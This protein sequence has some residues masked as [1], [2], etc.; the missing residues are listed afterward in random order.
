MLVYDIGLLA[1]LI[2]GLVF[3][4]LFM[5]KYG[6]VFDV[7][8]LPCLTCISFAPIAWRSAPD[9]LLPNQMQPAPPYTAYAAFL[10]ASRGPVCAQ[11]KATYRVYDA[12]NTAQAR[13]FLPVKQDPAV[14][15]SGNLVSNSA[16]V[17]ANPG[18]NVS[19]MDLDALNIS[20]PY[21][22]GDPGRW[23]TP[24]HPC[25]RTSGA[26]HKRLAAAATVLCL[27]WGGCRVWPSIVRAV[28]WLQAPAP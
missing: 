9:E 3:Y 22:A 1:A 13:F 19:A 25:R 10:T 8:A 23:A 14:P 18:L 21:N 15:A 11:A 7:S 16:A 28:A 24:C 17:M 20:M 6:V 26:E 2:T 12:P 5:A 27:C 4:S